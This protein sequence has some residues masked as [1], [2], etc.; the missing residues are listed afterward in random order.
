MLQQQIAPGNVIAFRA[1]ASRGPREP[2][3]DDAERGRILL[4]TGVRYERLR[5]E[6]PAAEAEALATDVDDIW[7]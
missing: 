1:L 3:S 4:F 6:E 2:S 5:P 7:A